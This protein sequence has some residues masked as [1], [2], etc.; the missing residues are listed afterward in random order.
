MAVAVDSYSGGLNGPTGFATSI[1]YSF[2]N[3]AGNALCLLGVTYGSSNV[4]VISTGSATYGGQ[5]LTVSQT[6]F[7]DGLGGPTI[8]VTGYLLNAPT[9][10]NTVVFNS[11]IDPAYTAQYIMARAISVSGVNTSSTPTMVPAYGSYA[12]DDTNQTFSTSI[13]SAT[14]NL[15]VGFG[16]YIPDYLSGAELVSMTGTAI[17][18]GATQYIWASSYPGAASVS[19]SV[20]G[21]LD[22]GNYNIVNLG[23]GAVSFAPSGGA[24]PHA[25]LGYSEVANQIQ[26]TPGNASGVVGNANNGLGDDVGGSGLVDVYTG[27][28]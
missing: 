25:Y 20:T 16:A 4:G 22:S 6:S 13:S 12:T 18:Q 27:V 28:S 11:N 26:T 7:D 14:N 1:S 19:V 23:I 9:G 24:T 3:T 15:V 21:F 8:I 17:E 2:T 10:A 5:L